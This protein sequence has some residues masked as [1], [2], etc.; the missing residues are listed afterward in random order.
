VFQQSDGL[1]QGAE[2]SKPDYRDGPVQ[3]K[4]WGTQY[5]SGFALLDLISAQVFFGP[6][7]NVED[8]ATG[9]ANEAKSGAFVC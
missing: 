8:D 1:L 6:D 4:R 5:L 2:L 9:C 7:P 3:V